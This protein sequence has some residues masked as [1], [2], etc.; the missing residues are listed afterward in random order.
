MGFFRKSAKQNFDIYSGYSWH[1]PGIK[2]MFVMLAWLLAGTIIG[3][4]VAEVFTLV[5]GQSSMDYT[6]LI[7]YPLMFIP[8]MIAAKYASSRNMMFETGYA[9]DS[10]HFGRTGGW[11]LAGI[12]TV[13]TIACSFPLDLTTSIL[14]PMPDFLKEI[15]KNMTQGKLWVNFL[16][17]SIFAPFFEE[18]LCRGTI[19]RGLLNYKRK[20][21]SNMKPVIAITISALAFAIIHMNPWQAIPAFLLGMLMGYVYY[22]TGSLKLTMLI[23]FVNNTTA[24]TIANIEQFKD[25][26]TW[27][28]VMPKSTFAVICIASVLLIA[29]VV[30][31]IIG[32]IEAQTPQGSCDAIEPAGMTQPL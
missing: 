28:D 24:L 27:L 4:L 30:I 13:T 2:G 5:S 9:M 22:K 10:S 19:L 15:L 12:L 7:S 18:W 6:M 8:P 20:D 11:G 26:E 32:K 1:V 21:G 29:F 23:H 3:S 25:A 14:P 16:S 31:G 17:V